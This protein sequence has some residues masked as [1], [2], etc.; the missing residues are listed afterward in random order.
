MIA[1]GKFA[2]MVA[3]ETFT[4]PDR[5]K[6]VE[7]QDEGTP[8]TFGAAEIKAY[9]ERLEQFKKDHKWT[10]GDR[11]PDI[12]L[13][14]F[15]KPTK[16]EKAGDQAEFASAKKQNMDDK[17]PSLSTEAPKIEGQA[18]SDFFTPGK[19]LPKGPGSTIDV[20]G[21]GEKSSLARTTITIA[22]AEAMGLKLS[23][24]ELEIARNNG[25]R[26]PWLIGT[27]ANVVD[28]SAEFIAKGS[29]KSLPQKAGISGTT[30]RFM[31]VTSLLGGDPTAS[32][33]AAIGALQPIEAHTIYEIGSAA[34][35]FGLDFNP[36]RPYSD[37]GID[38][39]TL[40]Q[41]ARNTG[42]PLSELNGETKRD[43][44]P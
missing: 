4:H 17:I 29:E 35:G 1:L 38:R 21:Q 39:E 22:E 3:E 10:D 15:L 36:E 43:K 14:S 18:D 5:M 33:L 12:A 30:F 23:P 2:E 40:E 16:E 7:A 20:T 6:K 44:K 28:P 25:G 11:V 8:G 26:L 37:L 32:R 42:V 9:R 31:E 24:R 27:I 34:K 41:L 19:P 13:A